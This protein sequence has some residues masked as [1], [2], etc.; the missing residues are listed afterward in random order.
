MSYAAC[1]TKSSFI[2]L[3]WW[4]PLLK[5]SSAL[6]KNLPQVVSWV[7]EFRD[8]EWSHQ[9]MLFTCAFHHYTYIDVDSRFFGSGDL[10]INERY[11]WKYRIHLNEAGYE[12]FSGMIAEQVLPSPEFTMDIS[13]KMGNDNIYE[14]AYA[15]GEPE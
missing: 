7:P 6:S 12:I 5:Y 4:Q 15:I 3:H 9:H 8:R 1:Q 11:F 10:A 2:M 14:Y 13:K